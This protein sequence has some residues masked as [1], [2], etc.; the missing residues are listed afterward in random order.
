MQLD[1]AATLPLLLHEDPSMEPAPRSTPFAKQSQE[2]CRFDGALEGDARDETKR[3][4]LVATEE[5]FV[6]HHVREHAA[7]LSAG[8][9]PKPSYLIP[10]TGA[11]LS[12]MPTC[13]A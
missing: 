11:Q 5:L 7:H 1:S 6:D 12:R 9:E 8:Q 13:R 4:P 10:L 2:H 3:R